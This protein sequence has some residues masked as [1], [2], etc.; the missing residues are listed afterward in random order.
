MKKSGMQPKVGMRIIGP[1]AIGPDEE[2]KV[3]C[4]VCLKGLVS[5]AVAARINELLAGEH[6]GPSSPSLPP[7]PT[8]P[9]AAEPEPPSTPKPKP[10]RRAP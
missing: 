7:A 9:P 6:D 4:P 3:P 8:L 2:T 10:P 5:P 1:N